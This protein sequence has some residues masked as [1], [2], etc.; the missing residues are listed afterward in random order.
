[1]CKGCPI[2]S[3]NSLAD[4]SFCSTDANSVE[5]QLQKLPK[6]RTGENVV[7]IFGIWYQSH[8]HCRFY[9][10]LFVEWSCLDV[11]RVGELISLCACN[12]LS[13]KT[14]KHYANS[15]NLILNSISWRENEIR[16]ARASF[17]VCYSEFEY[18]QN[19]TFTIDSNGVFAFI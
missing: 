9:E 19:H 14:V 15:C 5:M 10:N 11:W 2:Y 8:S 12:R 3:P 6:S 18:L 7:Q 1:M 4:V 17:V 13:K 16:K